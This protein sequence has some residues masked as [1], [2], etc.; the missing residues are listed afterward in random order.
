MELLVVGAGITGSLT[1]ALLARRCQELA[2]GLTVWDK[3]RGAGGR[4]STH[5]LPADPSMHVDMGAQYISRFQRTEENLEYQKQKDEIYAELI[6][7]EILT[8][9]CGKIDGELESH[10]D[11]SKFVAPKGLSNI[12]KYFLSQSSATTQFQQ[13][14]IKAELNHHDHRHKILC[15]TASQLQANFDA[16]VLT[17]PV[18]QMLALQGNLIGSIDPEIITKLSS[19]KYSSRF[20]LGLFYD[21]A[22]AV[23]SCSW[24]GKYIDHPVIR[25]ASWDTAKRATGSKGKTLLLHTSV[26]FGIKHFNS[27]NSEVQEL[28]EQTL[29]ELIPGLPL[30]CHSYL[31]RWRYSQVSQPYPGYPGCVVLSHNPLVIA[32]G[33]AFS[34]SSFDGCLYAANTT[35][36]LLIQY[37]QQ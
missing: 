8:P 32:T 26:P 19:V 3:A 37:L 4:M 17:V 31:L 15:T 1:A 33:D 21:E 6:S 36:K 18:P 7:N 14:L 30:S 34:E 13:Q 9:F 10:A 5:R 22:A 24:S 23:P 28:I 16:M 27:T 2:V 35:A 20:A 11:I 12:A 25:Y 29:K